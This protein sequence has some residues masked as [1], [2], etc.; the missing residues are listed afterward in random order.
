MYHRKNRVYFEVGKLV[1]RAFSSANTGGLSHS[2]RLLRD[3]LSW[4]TS[5]VDNSACIME[6]WIS[7]IYWY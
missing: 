4:Q 2:V 7:G 6:V 5:P 3:D 1:M